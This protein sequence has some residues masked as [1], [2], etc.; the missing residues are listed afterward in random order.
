MIG[1]MSEITDEVSFGQWDQHLQLR[2][3]MKQVW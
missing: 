3:Q 2:P 1:L